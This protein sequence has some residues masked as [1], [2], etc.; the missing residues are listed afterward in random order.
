MA[1]ITAIDLVRKARIG[2]N[3]LNEEVGVGDG[4]TT[5]FSF[6]NQRVVPNS[7]KVYIDGTLKT[8]GT[9][10]TINDN[11]GTI[12]FTGAPSV[13]EKITADYTWV[14][15]DSV[16]IKEEEYDDL[17]SQAEG[18]VKRRTQRVY[19][20]E[21]STSQWFD[22]VE[23][24]YDQEPAFGGVLSSDEDY[25][26]SRY[27]YQLNNKP[28][29][30]ISHIYKLRNGKE[31]NQV[32]G[33]DVTYTDNTDE[34]NSVGGTAFNIFPDGGTNNY[35]YL[36][37]NDRFSNIYFVLST[38]A[39]GTGVM[40]DGWEY[41]NG[42]TWSTLTVIDGTSEL[43]ADG[44]ISFT[45]PSDWAETTVNNSDSLY[46]I[47]CQPSTA[48]SVTNPTALQIRLDQDYVIEEEVDLTEVAVYKSTGIVVLESDAPDEGLRNLRIDYKYG[49]ASGSPPQ[50]YTD[51]IKVVRRNKVNYWNA[52]RQFR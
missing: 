40:N 35:L 28:V 34:A 27:V 31:W 17:I 47:R 25:H 26:A 46:F 16:D 9:D 49:L 52:C 6:D 1:L 42:S 30:V 8:R 11:Y 38:V 43:T 5:D 32:W 33:F 51:L 24:V 3:E 29:T 13:D 21:V 22:G 50:E 20:S 36:G 14:N 4:S 39:G 10:Y 19:E 18:Y 23:S 37:S 15:P 12:S 7:D 45:L 41:Y 2:T 48:F 44:S